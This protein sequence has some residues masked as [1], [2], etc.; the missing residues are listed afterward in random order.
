MMRDYSKMVCKRYLVIVNHHPWARI[1]LWLLFAFMVFKMASSLYGHYKSKKPTVLMVQAAE[2][3]TQAMPVLLKSPGSISAIYTVS[4]TPQVTGTIKRIAIQRGE[5]VKKGQLLFEIDQAP[6]L[7]SLRQAKSALLRDEATLLQNQADATRYAALAK[8]EYV[9]RQQAEQTATVATSQAAIVEADRAQVQ[10]AEI[11]LSYTNIRAPITGRTGEFTV[12]QGDLVVANSAMPL[13]VINKSDPVWV[14]FNLTQSQL[15]SVRQYQ[16]KDPL[17]VN[18]FSDAD[19]NNPLGTGDLALIDNVINPQ[20]GTVLLKAKIDN[21]EDKL[22][23]G[24]MVNAE[25]ILTIEPHAI[26]VPG[27]AIQFDQIGNFVYCIEQGKA[28]VKR[29]VVSR[30]IKGMVVIAQGLIGDEVVITTIAPDLAEGSAVKIEPT[31]STATS[32]YKP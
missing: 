14:S 9:T 10:Q 24:M 28:S 16:Q 2:V 30:Q 5:L 22:W 20:T 25:L 8:K 6:S 21:P 19:A 18:V 7:E 17:I 15:L 26:V 1:A 11:Q 32:E 27:N 31:G 12:N 13:L 29:V 4:I 3:R 23:P